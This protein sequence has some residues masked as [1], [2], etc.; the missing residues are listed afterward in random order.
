MT[1]TTPDYWNHFG[2]T[3]YGS[4]SFDCWVG[5][6]FVKG[7]N[8]D[9]WEGEYS[10]YSSLEDHLTYVTLDGHFGPGTWIINDET[11]TATYIGD[12]CSAYIFGDFFPGAM[13]EETDT[14]YTYSYSFID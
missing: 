13:G 3:Y 7:F 12:S 6:E 14:P 4:L 8:P 9:P 11:R 10:I 5:S 1:F 2:A